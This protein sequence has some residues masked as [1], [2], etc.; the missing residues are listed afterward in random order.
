MSADFVGIRIVN[1]NEQPGIK[2][3]SIDLH[4]LAEITNLLPEAIA[5]WKVVESLDLQ[6]YLIYKNSEVQLANEYPIF[7]IEALVYVLSELYTAALSMDKP[8]EQRTSE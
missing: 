3:E 7:E 6:M 8:V 4:T 2:T 1:G 5:K